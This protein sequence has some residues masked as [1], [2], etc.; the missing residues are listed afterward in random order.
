MLTFLVFT[1]D[2]KHLVLV[3]RNVCTAER[4]KE[5]LLDHWRGHDSVGVHT[6]SAESFSAFRDTHGAFFTPS[7]RLCDISAHEEVIA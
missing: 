5:R 4:L 7:T 2:A 1:Q 3:F 6:F